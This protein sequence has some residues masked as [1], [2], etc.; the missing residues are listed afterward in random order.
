MKKFFSASVRTVNYLT[1]FVT[2]FMKKFFSASVRTVYYLTIFVTTF[3][4]GMWY[5]YTFGDPLDGIRW[6][7]I[8]VFISGIVGFGFSIGGVVIAIIIDFVYSKISS[9]ISPPEETEKR[10][11]P[12]L[13]KK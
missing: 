5:N 1:I 6:A 8:D 12:D 3:A 4:T 10:H 7:G 9:I 2:T 11:L 13:T